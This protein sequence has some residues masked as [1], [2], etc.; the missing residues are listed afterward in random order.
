MDLS[1]NG[2][3]ALITGASRGIGKSCAL[4]LAEEGVIWLSA[5][6]TRKPLMKRPK[7]LRPKG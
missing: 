1:L 7:S 3:V 2:K 5:P 6:E 4:T